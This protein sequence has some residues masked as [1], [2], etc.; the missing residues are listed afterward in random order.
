[1]GSQGLCKK[2]LATFRL[3]ALSLALWP[4]MALAE[5]KEP[6]DFDN[7]T[8]RTLG[9][10]PAI[11]QYFSREP[12]FAPGK[13]PVTLTVNG[14]EKGTT[15]AHFSASGELCFDDELLEQAELEVP[16]ESKDAPCYDYRNAWPATLVNQHPGQ[17]ELEII[18][19]TDALVNR[20]APGNYQ[21]GGNA[22]VL[23]YSLFAMR[24][25]YAGTR[26][27]YSQAIIN[28]GLNINDWL[29]RTQQLLTYSDG[30][31]NANNTSTWLEHT[32]VG[33][34]TTLRAGEV[35]TNNT[36]LDGTSLYG[37]TLSPEQTLRP[38]GNSVEVKGIANSAQARVEIRQNSRLVYSTLVPLGPFMLTDFPVVNRTSDL[39]VTVVE[40]NGTEQHFIVPAATYNQNIGASTGLYVSLGRVDDNYREKPWVA[41]ISRGKRITNMLH[42]N[43]GAMATQ[44][45]QAA[46]AGV[47]VQL[48]QMSI[49][50]EIAG[51]NNRKKNR[52]GQKTSTLFN[53]HL[54]ERLSLSAG[55][56]HSTRQYRTLSDVLDADNISQNKNEFSIGLNWSHD[57]PGSLNLS[58]RQSESYRKNNNSRYLALGWARTFRHNTLSVHWQ[59]QMGAGSEQTNKDLV[60]VNL[61]IPLGRSTNSTLYS[62]HDNN[63]TRY[64]ATMNS[65]INDELN[66]LVGAESSTGHEGSAISGGL[67]ANL[68]Y[69]QLN[70]NANAD[71]DDKNGRG[72][73]ATMQGGIAAHRHGVTF[74]P[75]PIDETFAIAHLDHGIAGVKLETPHGSVWTDAWG[76]A[77]VPTLPPYRDALVQMSTETLPRNVDVG[78][79]VKRLSQGRGSVGNVN[80]RMLVQRRVMLNVTLADGKKLP[81]GIAIEDDSGNYLTTV[82]DDGVVFINN[83]L[84]Q[85]TLVASLDDSTCHIHLS[86]DEDAPPDTFYETA[87]EVCK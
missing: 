47:Y 40:A 2:V 39:A 10:D 35:N 22:G 72:Y 87:A 5:E 38:E 84:P 17:E 52:Q 11:S 45:Y 70:V 62:R 67:N 27:D 13:I 68:H 3:S 80:F 77:V 73:S 60:Y 55:V 36:L 41:S 75:L 46:A 4:F 14:I 8:L 30:K 65:T 76:R 25:E 74:S 81:R 78:N 53:Y 43:G 24:N 19:P 33:P 29:L 21:T 69:T 6:I 9:L 18:V 49:A 51:S 86:L 1:M 85:Q 54:A 48:P 32:F 71:A 83:A 59:H 34:K 7:E 79:G 37:I 61:S 15:V 31:Y 23:N 57:I 16:P 20:D 42:L 50:T 82:V 63:K 56:A 66:Y 44:E 26:S 64:G 12:R 58:Y 28:G